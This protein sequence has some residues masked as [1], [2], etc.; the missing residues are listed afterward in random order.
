MFDRCANFKTE[1]RPNRSDYKRDILLFI[2]WSA[3][4]TIHL[5]F[6][7]LVLYKAKRVVCHHDNDDDTKTMTCKTRQNIELMKSNHTWLMRSERLQ[8]PFGN[9]RNVFPRSIT[10]SNRFPPTTYCLE[11]MYSEARTSHDTPAT[12][13]DWRTW[14]KFVPRLSPLIVTRIPPST[15]PVSG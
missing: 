13:T 3:K 2:Q 14:S 4:I 5:M 8:Q 10:L 12:V 7:V 15:R 6:V 11:T 9:R 1:Y